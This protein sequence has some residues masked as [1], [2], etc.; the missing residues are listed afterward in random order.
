MTQS[1]YVVKTVQELHAIHKFV[2]TVLTITVNP[3][4]YMHRAYTLAGAHV[5]HP[6]RL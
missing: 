2:V 1:C 6:P 3:V 4:K 5:Y